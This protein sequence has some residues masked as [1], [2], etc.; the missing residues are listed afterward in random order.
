MFLQQGLLSVQLV[1]LYI[2]FSYRDIG[3][4]LEV[5]TFAFAGHSWALEHIPVL[6]G[7]PSIFS[8]GG[9]GFVIFVV[10]YA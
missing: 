7:W 9:V 1:L 5:A 10:S 4:F 8:A 2:V 6:G 3:H